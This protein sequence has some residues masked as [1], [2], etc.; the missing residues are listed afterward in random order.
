[1]SIRRIF[2][3]AKKRSSNKKIFSLF[4]LFVFSVM[5]YPSRLER[6][7]VTVC[8]A[9]RK[10]VAAEWREKVSEAACTKGFSKKKPF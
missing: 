7:A 5:T 2:N 3:F 10:M 1:M 9:R 4:L 6:R 8:V